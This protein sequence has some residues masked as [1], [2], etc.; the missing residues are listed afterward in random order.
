MSPLAFSVKAYPFYHHTIADSIHFDDSF[1]YIFSLFFYLL[2]IVR[3]DP[4]HLLK[5]PF[6]IS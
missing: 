6:P 4:Q 5:F 1:N 3:E 2:V